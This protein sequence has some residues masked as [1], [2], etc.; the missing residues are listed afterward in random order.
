MRGSLQAA[1]L[2]IFMG[3][4]TATATGAAAQ[5]A[6]NDSSAMIAKVSPSVVNVS[7]ITEA[8]MMAMMHG[9]GEGSARDAKVETSLGTGF[10]V[11]PKGLIV[12]NRHVIQGANL[13]T[14]TLPDGR[15]YT[16]EVVAAASI[17]DLA[18]LR[19]D[20]DVTLPAVAL[21]DSARLRVGQ[22]VIAIGNPLGLG[23][24][25]SE[26]IVSALNRDLGSTPTDDYIQ[27]DAAI[28]HGNSGGPLFNEQ[29]QVIGIDTAFE[30]PGGSANG[31]VGL[32]F[33]I[34]ANHI[35]YVLDMM[36]AYGQVRAGLLGA[37]TQTLTPELALALGLPPAGGAIVTAVA[38]GGPAAKAGLAVG[39]VIG[40]V[41]DGDPITDSRTLVRAAQARKP[42]TTMTLD[43][44][45]AGAP[46]TLAVV[47]GTWP[48]A[49]APV[50]RRPAVVH[51]AMME[52]MGLHDV[53]PGIT[54][55]AAR[56]PGVATV[57]TVAAGDGAAAAGIRAGDTI[58][59]VQQT[60]VTNEAAL[61]A[62]LA[63]ARHAGRPY[64]AVLIDR[65]GKRGWVALPLI[66]RK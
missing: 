25:V 27:T 43:M 38:Q 50:P 56:Q 40:S 65:A 55:A 31:S 57:A 6:A 8:G 64:A 66:A 44:L 5:T 22:K 39:D 10:I 21:G 19:I 47:L 62:A 63:A 9:A 41:D 18:L 13:I 60:P 24:S 16:A 12:T 36:R 1:V 42:G 23:G 2:A 53:P 15:T 26:G 49:N 32:G 48:D 28:N 20:P 34:P 14:V 51:A 11:D 33:A 54:L 59:M 35:R 7:A 37:T 45:H 3:M 58:V 30:T 61:E 17:V 4:A 52:V 46:R 29:G